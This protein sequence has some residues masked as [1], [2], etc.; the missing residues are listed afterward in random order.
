M[1][2]SVKH[3][4]LCISRDL[5]HLVAEEIKNI[6]Q[7]LPFE[8]SDFR[9]CVKAFGQREA[10]HHKKQAQQMWLGLRTARHGE[11]S[12][13]I[14]S[15]DV[16]QPL[17]LARPL[18]T[19][20]ISQVA[21]PL[22]VKCTLIRGMTTSGWNKKENEWIHKEAGP[23]S[24]AVSVWCEGVNKAQ[25]FSPDLCMLMT[26]RVYLAAQLEAQFTLGSSL[27]Y[28]L[29]SFTFSLHRHTW[30]QYSC[31]RS[32]EPGEGEGNGLIMFCSIAKSLCL[33]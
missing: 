13:W 29:L 22:G 24:V 6:W 26:G 5:E 8:M 31:V 4:H 25:M 15:L 16:P 11:P 12:L 32:K 23:G 10:G 17:E 18:L 21:F 1:Y 28:I 7:Q 19:T 3:N 20:L 30:V 2:A 27:L 14:S 33:W 9:N